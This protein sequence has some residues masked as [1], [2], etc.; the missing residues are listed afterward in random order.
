MRRNVTFFVAQSEK[1]I[2][3]S[4]K[5]QTPIQ[6]T[7]KKW[8]SQFTILSDRNNFYLCVRNSRECYIS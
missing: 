6:G 8:K 2:L 7:G 3:K 4:T 1:D 5:L